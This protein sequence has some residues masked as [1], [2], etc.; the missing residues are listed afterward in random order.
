MNPIERWARENFEVVEVDSVAR[1]YCEGGPPSFQMP[2]PEIERELTPREPGDW[3]H[4]VC[5]LDIQQ[6]LRPDMRVLDL[7]CGPGWPGVP[8]SASVRQVVATDKSS[9]SMSLLTRNLQQRGAANV[10]SVLADASALPFGDATFDVVV[11]SDLMNMVLDPTAVAG[12]AFRVLRPGGRIV[13]W[14]QNFRYVLGRDGERCTRSVERGDG[15]LVY[16]LHVAAVE[17]P[18]SVELR[19][20]V[21][22]THVAADALAAM[23]EATKCT[24][25][26][27]LTEL[28]HLR[29]ALASRVE[30]YREHEFVPETAARPFATAGF[31]E[32]SVS[33]LSHEMCHAFADELARRRSLPV[34]KNEFGELAA[35]L[36]AAMTFADS[37]RSS[38][39]SVK[40]RRPVAA[41]GTI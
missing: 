41:S 20:R 38:L 16:I 29:P 15:S 27:G 10:E 4:M 9:L 5:L 18:D 23:Q 33:P 13:S 1:K 19:F 24:V 39:I 6:L 3:W 11:A 37:D 25:E 40:G 26:V 21:D 14:V 32:L 12:E 2:W 8:L 34:T 17:P 7:G 30:L 22:P 36:L 28:R 31:T 35:A